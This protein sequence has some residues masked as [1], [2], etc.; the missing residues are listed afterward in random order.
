MLHINNLNF[1]PVHF[2]MLQLGEKYVMKTGT[3]IFGPWYQYIGSLEKNEDGY[4][5]FS[6]V[7]LTNLKTNETTNKDIVM[8][9]VL[10]PY[11][12]YSLS[13]K[14]YIIQDAMELRAVNR[15]LQQ[16]TGEDTFIY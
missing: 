2:S 7:V 16:A 13:P 8:I 6:C 15:V 14:K 11:T 4:L 1:K 12:Y 5:T 10:Q 9:H 3:K